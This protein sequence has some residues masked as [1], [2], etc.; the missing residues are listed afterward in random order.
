MLQFTAFNQIKC[1]YQYFFF[2][3][4]VRVKQTWVKALWVQRQLHFPVL[5]S[6]HREHFSHWWVLS[7]RIES[8]SGTE[9]R[10]KATP[11]TPLAELLVQQKPWRLWTV[12]TQERHVNIDLLQRANNFYWGFPK[13]GA[14]SLTYALNDIIHSDV[15]Q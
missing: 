6:S 10:G 15:L 5:E 2:L 1:I 9:G 8:S 13:P 4:T 14:D 12:L 7:C 3:S 11:P